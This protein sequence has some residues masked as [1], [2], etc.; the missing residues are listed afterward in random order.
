MADRTR[1]GL[2][3]GQFGRALYDLDE[4]E[5]TFERLPTAGAV[6]DLLGEPEQ[7]SAPTAVEIATEDGGSN[8]QIPSVRHARETQGII[9]AHPELQPASSLLPPLLR[10]GEAVESAT[11]HHDPLMGNLLAVGTISSEIDKNPVSVL[12]FS[13]GPAGNHLRIVELKKQRQGWADTK[14]AW[15]EVPAIHGEQTE[16]L[17]DGSPIQ[18]ISFARALEGGDAS[19]AV[20]TRTKTFIFWPVLRRRRFEGPSKSRLDVNMVFELPISMTG[21]SSHVDVA[22]NPWYNRQFAVTD[23]IGCWSVWELVGRAKMTAR[24]ILQSTDANGEREG[25]PAMDDGRKRVL[26][27]CDPTV[28]AHATRDHVSLFRVDDDTRWNTRIDIVSLE[29][30]QGWILDIAVAPSH[31]SHLWVLTA[32]RLVVYLVWKDDEGEL[33]YRSV[34]S[35]RHYRN[36]EDIT[37]SML[38]FD[39]NDDLVVLL[40]SKLDTLTISF[41]FHF[42]DDKNVNVF[43]PTS[44][45]GLSRARAGLQ[46]M[47]TRFGSRF[48]QN[49][50]HTVSQWRNTGIR[51]HSLLSLGQHHELGQQLL[52]SNPST[53]A[54][55]L[56]TPPAWRGLLTAKSSTRLP[57]A[58]FVVDDDDDDEAEEDAEARRRKR[59]PATSFL[60]RRRLL[61]SA[62]KGADETFALERMADGLSGSKGQMSA[63]T[64]MN[65]ARDA[66][67]QQDTEAAVPLRTLRDFGSSEL[68]FAHTD[69]A[70]SHLADLLR[71]GTD[72]GTG[73]GQESASER[74]TRLAIQQTCIL[75]SDSF[76]KI[77]SR[78]SLADVYNRMID[79]WISPLSAHISGRTRLAKEQCVRQVAMDVVL[80]SHVMRVEDVESLAQEPQSSRQ[81][82]WELPIRGVKGVSS[83]QDIP[84]SNYL[85]PSSE[86]ESQQNVLPTPSPTATPS[87]MTGSSATSIFAPEAI[88]LAK[89]TAFSKP[90]VTTLP[91]SLNNVLSHWQPGTDPSDYDW[92]TTSRRIRHIDEELEDSAGMT[93]KERARMQRRA[94]RHIRRQRKEAAAS[95]AAQFASSQA[96]EIAISASQPSGL[97]VESQPTGAPAGNLSQGL[98]ELSASQAVRGRF[99]GRPAKKKRKQGF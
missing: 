47:P 54:G 58:Q 67:D 16:W 52:Y 17:G 81:Q 91:R 20:R 78:P 28:L 33:S 15:I 1:D 95:Q 65:A 75:G 79:E 22:F 97:K 55:S 26:W 48:L 64:V 80:A 31:P 5:W 27:V 25:R 90:A 70:T 10:V 39:D 51:F 11:E 43:D 89:Y 35:V 38:V 12:A 73:K 18:Q 29:S 21:G 56:L 45:C 13:G 7:I 36:P 41:R 34:T 93:E 98:G 94:E 44:I 32:H 99:G 42:Q 72:E 83:Y 9:K 77:G 59:K 87:I 86:L 37:L 30:A 88:R 50:T 69:E 2:P 62:P 46:I 19:L 40:C 71:D 53:F 84:S 57:R 96:P 68:T 60:H 61:V 82:D 85:G 92:L 66:L 3:Y 4:E 8:H 23:H 6:L 14:N 24:P 74:T 76:P 49:D 63:G